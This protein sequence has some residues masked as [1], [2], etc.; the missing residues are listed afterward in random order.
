MWRQIVKAPDTPQ[1]P[2]HF[3]E[4]GPPALSP[5]T[6]PPWI[7]RVLLR[8]GGFPVLAF[9]LNQ[10]TST[11][12]ALIINAFTECNTMPPPPV[13]TPMLAKTSHKIDGATLF[14]LTIIVLNQSWPLTHFL[15]VVF[16]LSMT[17]SRCLTCFFFSCLL[18]RLPYGFMIIQN[19]V[20]VSPFWLETYKLNNTGKKKSQSSPS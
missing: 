8:R 16:S 4:K 9:H 12:K 10:A 14:H 7:E 3:Q 20:Q 6:D 17:D 15:E 1:C 18:F 13:P 19:K 11:N 5:G 2:S